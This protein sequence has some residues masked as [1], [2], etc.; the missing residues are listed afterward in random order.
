M[1]KVAIEN[2]TGTPIE[3]IDAFVEAEEDMDFFCQYYNTEWLNDA[4]RQVLKTAIANSNEESVAA[5]K[6]KTCSKEKT[7]T[8]DSWR[9]YGWQWWCGFFLELGSDKK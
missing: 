6:T 4:K 1:L 7:A 3:S 2:A 8:G 9:G 5:F